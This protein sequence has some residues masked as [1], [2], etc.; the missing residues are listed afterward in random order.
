MGLPGINVPTPAMSEILLRIDATYGDPTR[1]RSATELEARLS[2]LPGAPKDSGRLS[3]IIRRPAKD[4]R[5]LLQRAQISMGGGL[6]GDAWGQN[7]DRN[8]EAQLTLMQ[9]DVAELIANGQS[10]SLFGDNLLVDLDLSTPNLPAGSRLRVGGA[11]LE[12]TPLPHNGCRKFD[13]R[14]GNDALRFVNAKPTR[15]LNLRGI[16]CRVIESGEVEIGSPV[17]VLS[18]SGV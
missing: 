6:P 2:A 3:F 16:H 1:H 13:A 9:R 12:V 11:V 17:E 14:F 15:H 10:P 7:P 4:T 18:R 5:E 8:P